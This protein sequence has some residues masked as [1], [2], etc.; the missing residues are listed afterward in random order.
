LAELDGDEDV[1]G[2]GVLGDCDEQA[3]RKA[4]A[5]KAKSGLK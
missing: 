2:E 1:S 5:A 4:E 3:A